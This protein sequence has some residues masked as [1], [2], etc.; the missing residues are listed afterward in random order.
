MWAAL[1]TLKKTPSFSKLTEYSLLFYK[2][3]DMFDFFSSIKNRLS[4]LEAKVEQLLH[5]NLF[6]N[7]VEVPEEQPAAPAVEPTSE[8]K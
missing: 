7:N 8:N 2:V 1:K 3:Y 4:E 5:G 6:G